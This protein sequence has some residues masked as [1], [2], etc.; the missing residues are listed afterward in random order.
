MD[1]RLDYRFADTFC[2]MPTPDHPR[3]GGH[4]I[5]LRTP[6]G[7]EYRYLGISCGELA[8][9]HVDKLLRHVDHVEG[10]ACS[11]GSVEFQPECVLR[12]STDSWHE[13]TGGRDDFHPDCPAA[14]A[15]HGLAD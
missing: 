9:G 8:A 15:S 11:T 13:W 2:C 14:T 4:T 10:K 1:H 5:I 7:A 3:R 12:P 6:W